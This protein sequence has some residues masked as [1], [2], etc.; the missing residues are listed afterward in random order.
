V[1]VAD[2]TLRGRTQLA[3]AVSPPR[4]L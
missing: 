3:M 4:S 1:D 2:E